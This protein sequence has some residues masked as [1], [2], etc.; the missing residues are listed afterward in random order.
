MDLNT[1][2]SAGA[3][4]IVAI[5]RGVH[6]DEVLAIARAL[7]EGGVRIIEVPLNSPAPLAS[8]ERLAS[9]CG[10]Q[11]L[12]GAGT[13]TSVE[14]VDAVIA[15]GGRLIVAPNAE[16]AVIRRSLERGLDV[17]PG[18]MTPTEAFAALD[19][20]AHDI[21]LFPGGSLGPTHLRALREVLPRECRV[22]AVGGVD[23][24][25]LT[26]WRRAGASGVGVGGALYRPGSSVEA[27]RGSAE[28]L[29]KA[30]RAS[31]A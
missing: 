27:V 18:V 7:I 25:N 1:H 6:P 30:W 29:V 11:A 10:E 24:A 19:A 21:K 8:I 2:L 20:G 5:L 31:E 12:I 17:L 16:R 26:Q 3:P 14:A 15:A 13:V 9:E 22:W 23:A 28:Q 4:A